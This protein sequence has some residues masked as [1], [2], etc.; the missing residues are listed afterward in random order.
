MRQKQGPSHNFICTNVS[1]KFQGPSS[2]CNIGRKQP[3][4]KV[5]TNHKRGTKKGKECAKNNEC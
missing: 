5:V 4:N 1:D 2:A 3:L